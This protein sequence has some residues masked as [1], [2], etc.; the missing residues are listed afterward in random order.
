MV[1]LYLEKMQFILLPIEGTRNDVTSLS[2]TMGEAVN[3]ITDKFLYL[4]NE[5]GLLKPLQWP[6][7]SGTDIPSFQSCDFVQ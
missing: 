3:I 5:H 7:V 2:K 1:G 6:L 4:Y